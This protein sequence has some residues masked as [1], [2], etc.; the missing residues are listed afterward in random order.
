MNQR[1][2]K[3]SLRFSEAPFIIS[4]ASIVGTKEGGGPLGGLF[5]MV[6]K[7][8]KFGQNTW[9]E[10]ESSM[11]ADALSMALGKAK[12]RPEDIDYVFAGD[13]LGQSMATTFGLEKFK[14]PLFGVYGA[15]STCGETLSLAA[16]FAAA[17]YGD[18][19]AAVTSSHFGSAEKQF[20]F[21][22]QYAN[23]RPICAT[24][25]VTGS[26]AFI[27]S[28]NKKTGKD[29]D[30][31]NEDSDKSYDVMIEGITT[32]TVVDYGIKDSMNMGAAMAPAA[33]DVIVNHMKDFGRNP[34]YYDCI[35][36]GDLG[37]VGHTI[38]VDLCRQKGVDI[39]NEHEDCGIK[40]FDAVNQNTGS[41]GSGCGCSAT[42]LASYYIPKLRRGELKKILFIPTGAL[43]SPVSFNEGDTVPGIAHGV[44]LEACDNNR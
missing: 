17:G 28:K 26:G 36:T 8:D 15:C 30:K 34:S 10:A 35:V 4:E 21:P 1:I 19:I 5:D 41:G 44:V 24:W 9:E 11:Q 2:G 31:L 23:Q 22:N 27:L 3:W 40:I 38:L 32:G 33:C 25:T 20:R 42:V 6:G 37:E 43:L 13:L 12:R 29:A 18:Y 16:A 14:I 39:S 7:D